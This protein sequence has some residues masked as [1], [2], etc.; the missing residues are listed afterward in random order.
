MLQRAVDLSLS[1]LALLIELRTL[2]LFTKLENTSLSEQVLLALSLYFAFGSYS[3]SAPIIPHK[4]TFAQSE[5]CVKMNIDR[6][7]K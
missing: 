2:Y 7:S 3:L 6:W 5:V 4:K 1:V